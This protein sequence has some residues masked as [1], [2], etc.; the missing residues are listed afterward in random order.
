MKLP[1][2]PDRVAST[3]SRICPSLGYFT[4][5]K[6]TEPG[7]R[8]VELIDFRTADLFI[9]HLHQL[10][11]MPEWSTMSWSV[12]SMGPCECLIYREK[13]TEHH[14]SISSV[15]TLNPKWHSSISWNSLSTRN[16]TFSGSFIYSYIH[17]KPQFFIPKTIS[18]LMD[19]GS[20]EY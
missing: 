6:P 10:I 15:W 14:D 9:W 5:G 1:V 7:I 8:L 19:P 3:P 20:S 13:T 4:Y 12:L 16:V 17:I 18:H 11:W 2:Y